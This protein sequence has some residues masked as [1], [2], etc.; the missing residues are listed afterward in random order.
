MSAPQTELRN[1]ED[2]FVFTLE[3]VYDMEVKLVDALDEMSQLATNDNLSAGFAIHR[4][5]TE[6]QVRRVEEAFEALGKEPTRRDNRVI[7]GLLEERDRF[8]ASVKDDELRNL[9]Y[10]DFGIETERIEITSYEELLRI[11]KKIGVGEDV[12]TPLEDN[13]G[14]E[15]KTLRK[16]RGLAGKSTL[17]TLRD[18]LRAL[19]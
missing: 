17:D 15:G 5:E 14:Q 12:T 16:L 6:T 19:R 8:D 13:L 7:D 18:E 4:T 10:L 1:P 2:L 3:A 9:R 11:A